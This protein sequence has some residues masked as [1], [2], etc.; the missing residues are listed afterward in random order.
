LTYLGIDHTFVLVKVDEDEASEFAFK[1][2][3]QKYKHKEI[4]TFKECLPLF[5]MTNENS[6]TGPGY[7]KRRGWFVETGYD[8]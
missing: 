5:K 6:H 8:I 7:L 2:D 3:L 1:R 4:K